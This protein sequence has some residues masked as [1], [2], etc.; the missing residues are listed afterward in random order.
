MEWNSTFCASLLFYRLKYYLLHIRKFPPIIRLKWWHFLEYLLQ[1][2]ISPLLISFNFCAYMYIHVL[3]RFLHCNS[4]LIIVNFQ[5]NY[6]QMGLFDLFKRENTNNSDKN[7][8][9]Q[10]IK[11]AMCDGTIDEKENKFI[12]KIAGKFNLSDEDINDIKSNL[13]NI[14]FREPQSA[15]ARFQMV[16]DLVWLML[17]DGNIDVNEIHICSRVAMKMGYEPQ[18]V[19][20]LVNAIQNN[21]V[22]ATEPEAIYEKILANIE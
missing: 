11:V 15:K 14:K 19:E 18:I 2:L 20:D 9:K 10:L 22:D 16:F 4:L 7:Y 8:L 12:N 5:K 6:D 3:M 13:Q 21:L 17:I 1:P